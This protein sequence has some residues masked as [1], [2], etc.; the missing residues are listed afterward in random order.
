MSQ[1][2]TAAPN[3][4][5]ARTVGPVIIEA[6]SVTKSFT[7]PDGR[8]L[9]V[10]DAISFSLAEGEIVALLGKSG[11]GK[12]TLLRCVAGLI[13]PSGGTVAYRGTP[14]NGANPGVAMI[15][16]SFAL[17]P[18]LTVQQNVE[19]GLQARGVP[20]A[21]RRERALK[22]IDLIGLDGFESAYPK[23]LSGGMRQ[24]VG[25]ARAIVVEPDA[26]L[27]DEPFS[28]LDVL[29][30][31]NLRNELVGLWEGHEA[32]VKSILIVTHNIEEAVLLADRILVLSSNPG[33][34][35]AEL[36]VEL[37]RPRDR[38]AP[39]FESIVDTVYGILTGREDRATAAIAVA[40]H[41]TDGVPRPARPAPTP[42]NTPLPVVS[43]GGMAGLLEI[44][45]ARGG[46]DGLAEIA[47]ELNFEID[48]LLP[49]VDAAV[50]LGL[51]GTKGARLEITA[52]GREFA[53]ADILTSK[54]LFARH[55][56]AH[57]P[58]VRAIAQAL[59]ATEDHTLREG[60]FLDLLRRG[61]STEEARQQLE[62]AIDWG[63]YGELFDYDRDDAEFTLD[64]SAYPA[65]VGTA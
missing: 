38:H 30:A 21:E 25:F 51:A 35:K 37:P 47:D 13:A 32:P 63:R 33:R 3:P 23:E 52:D 6:E 2:Q 24:R 60:F 18:W 48:D 5:Q 44:L 43:P 42:I 27:M 4:A 50:M 41:P 65:L 55:A 34:I 58:L 20:E 10:L 46:E 15:F 19:L 29:T 39:R 53:A 64:P 1:S 59:T 49:L 12:S 57:A 61:Y 14:L 9:P 17:L 54:Q 22:A 26:L 45:A 8:A 40:E 62:T 28:A 31:E 7:N 11:S 16:Q 56:V 36:A